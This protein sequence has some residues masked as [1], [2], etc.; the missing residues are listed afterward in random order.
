MSKTCPPLLKSPT[1][2]PAI[3]LSPSNSRSSLSESESDNDFK[4]EEHTVHQA[5]DFLPYDEE[6]EPLATE[7]EADEYETTI[8]QQQELQSVA[9]VV[10]TL[11]SEW[12]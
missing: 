6:L 7:E 8:Q 2:R 3:S 4:T 10:G 9:K 5:V 11:V 12:A 1:G